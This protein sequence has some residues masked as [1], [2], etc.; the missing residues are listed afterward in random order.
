MFLQ[1]QKIEPLTCSFFFRTISTKLVKKHFL[2]LAAQ[3]HVA[4]LAAPM[5]AARRP[6]PDHVLRAQQLAALAHAAAA[7]VVIVVRL[8]VS[9]GE[10]LAGTPALVARDARLV[11]LA[12]P[13]ALGSRQQVVLFDYDRTRSRQ[14]VGAHQLRT[15]L[16]V[17]REGPVALDAVVGH[18]VARLTAH[19]LRPLRVRAEH[20]LEGKCAEAGRLPHRDREL[21]QRRV[22]LLRNGTELH[23]HQLRLVLAL[24]RQQV[25]T[26][27]A[28][29][30]VGIVTAFAL[31]THTWAVFLTT[32]PIPSCLE[33]PAFDT[34]IA[35]HV[36]ARVSVAV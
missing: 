25:A 29:L 22:R 28:L 11:P 9:V 19:K 18:A 36:V 8:G 31:N 24:A 26:A 14:L 5:A 32:R 20:L 34:R 3:P 23:P 16:D 7:P 10:E 4:Q 13:H 15:R 21:Q 27:R 30:S 6:V 33:R 35:I 12:V 17:A 1:K 2:S